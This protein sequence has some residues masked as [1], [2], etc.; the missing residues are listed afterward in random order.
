MHRSILTL[1]TLT[2]RLGRYVQ[3]LL[4]WLDNCHHDYCAGRHLAPLELREFGA[5]AGNS[6]NGAMYLFMGPLTSG[7]SDSSTAFAMFEGGGAYDYLGAY[8][9]TITDMDGDGHDDLVG[10]EYYG[11]GDV[12]HV[13][14]F[15]GGA[16]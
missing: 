6:S 3:L 15:N 11:S 9:T 2:A 16:M 14:I 8:G 5:Y 10:T 4:L 1:L 7:T 13:F 12:G